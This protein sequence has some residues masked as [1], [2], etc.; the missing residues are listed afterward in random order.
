MEVSELEKKMRDLQINYIGF[1]LIDDGRVVV[2]IEND[3]ATK[4]TFDEAIEAALKMQ[5][6]EI[7]RRIASKQSELDALYKHKDSLQAELKPA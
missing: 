2:S 6:R 5:D 4:D 1:R 7:D 3:S